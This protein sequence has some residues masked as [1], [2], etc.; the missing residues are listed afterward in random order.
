M[1]IA[2]RVVLATL[3]A[4][5]SVLWANANSVLGSLGEMC[6]FAYCTVCMFSVAR[7]VYVKRCNEGLS[8]PNSVMRGCRSY[9]TVSTKMKIRM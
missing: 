2:Q 6:V 1:Q 9:Q 4:M 5:S 7:P 3:L 8:L